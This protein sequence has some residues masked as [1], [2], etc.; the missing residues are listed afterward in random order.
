MDFADA[1]RIMRSGGVV[2]RQCLTETGLTCGVMAPPKDS[3]LMPFFA[4]RSHDG[5]VIPWQPSHQELFAEDWIAVE[6][7]VAGHG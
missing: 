3:G 1:F 4:V 6:G 2:T 5:M 7:E